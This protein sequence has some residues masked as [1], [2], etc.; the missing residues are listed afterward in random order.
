[1]A[2]IAVAGVIAGA[3]VAGA[4]GWMLRRKN[5][6]SPPVTRFTIKLPPGES[7][8]TLNGG[9]AF[10][11]D[12]TQLAYGVAGGKRLYL[13]AMNDFQPKTIPGAEGFTGWPVFSPDGQWV[14]FRQGS[15][16]KKVS[17]RGGPPVNMF[18]APLAGA[19]MAAWSANDSVVFG[20]YPAGMWRIPATGGNHQE[21]PVV[22]VDKDERWAGHPHFLPGGKAVMY[23][24][25]TKDADSPDE[26]SVAVVSLE[27]GKRKILINGG[28]LAHYSPSGHLVYVRG[29]ALNAVPFDVDRLAVT[30][31][32]V[33][34]LDG[35]YAN[36]VGQIAHFSISA[37]GSLA[38]AP[39]G[40][41]GVGRRVVWVNRAGKVQPLS[42]PPRAYLH[43][44]ISPDARRLAIEVEGLNHDV[45][46]YD[47]DRGTLTKMT[48]D[49]SSHS[50]LWTPDG[51]RLT[52]RSGMP[53]PFTMWSMPADRSGPAERLTSVGSQQSAASW[54]PDGRTVAY[55]QVSADTGGDI[56]VLEMGG[57]R[58]PRVFAQS[59]FDE[60]S[61]KFSPDGR[62]IAYCSNESGQNEIYV[63]AYPGPGPKI[64][65]SVEGGSD[66]V[67]KRQGGELYYRNGDKMMAVTVVAGS[68]LTAGKPKLLWEA[69]YN[70][71]MNS[72]CGAPGPTS[73]NY[74]VTADGQR[75]LMIQEGD[76]DA[77]ATEIRVVLNWSEELRR[78]T[79]AKKD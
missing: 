68:T 29:G 75:F 56:Y 60:G 21:V 13:R 70:Q 30:G 4:A 19:A 34:V 48:F 61:P 27:T 50:P 39:G 47:I 62:W 44:R 24:L 74:D 35:V 71:G 5:P 41:L 17:V 54:S 7:L 23:N 49:G 6:P 45:Y 18:D 73:S 52:Y 65:V 59:K 64:Q 20:V 76:R 67:W 14:A 11:A 72:M 32:P 31:P 79:A 40:S 57:E 28:R 15:K 51:Q 33:L 37:N 78:L 42:L 36:M 66:P 58:K 69:H 63:Q 43:P 38:Y 22:D 9:L 25:K 10:S 77:P 1:V 3:A 8:P 55:T 46:L 53:Q 26:L 16:W 2:V 12:G